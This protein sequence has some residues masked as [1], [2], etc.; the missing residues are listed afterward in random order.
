[1]HTPSAQAPSTQRAEAPGKP[2]AAPQRPQSV[3]DAR[4]SASQPLATS[5]SQSACAASHTAGTQREAS[6][7][8]DAGHVTSQAPQWARSRDAST[9]A[10]PQRISGSAQ[11]HAPETQAAPA[12]HARPQPP[13]C[14]GSRAGSTQTSPQRA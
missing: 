4:R 14:A 11:A 3:A 12:A 9:Q 8:E 10:S 1:M 2:H 13:Q 5:P 7:R 6:Q